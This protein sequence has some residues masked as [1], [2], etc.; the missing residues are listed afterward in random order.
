MR[1]FLESY[2]FQFCG[3]ERRKKELERNIICIEQNGPYTYIIGALEN[4]F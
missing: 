1:N 4:K 3:P 2:L